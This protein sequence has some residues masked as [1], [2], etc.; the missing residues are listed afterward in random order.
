MLL[1][2]VGANKVQGNLPGAPVHSPK[3][4]RLMETPDSINRKFSLDAIK[5]GALG[6]PRLDHTSC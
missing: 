3:Q 1:A 2:I 4:E 6:Q 5:F